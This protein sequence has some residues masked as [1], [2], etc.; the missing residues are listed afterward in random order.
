MRGCSTELLLR[1]CR[2][3]GFLG[4]LTF[5]GIRRV[6]A[7][8]RRTEDSTNPVR[9]YQIFELLKKLNTLLPAPMPS[10]LTAGSVGKLRSSPSQLRRQTVT[11]EEP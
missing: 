3:A 8:P 11:A 9:K 5:Q 10:A 1:C 2:P 4:R 7:E 6:E